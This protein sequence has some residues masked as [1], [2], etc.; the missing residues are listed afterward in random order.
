MRSIIFALLMVVFSNQITHAET[1][2][3]VKNG[4][5]SVAT[6]YGHTGYYYET[7]AVGIFVI[8]NGGTYHIEKNA[9]NGDVVDANGKRI[10][11]FYKF[12]YNPSTHHYEYHNGDVFISIPRKISTVL[13]DSKGI[14]YF[15]TDGTEATDKDDLRYYSNQ[16]ATQKHETYERVGYEV[17]DEGVDA[18]DKENKQR[19]A[20]I[21][22]QKKPQRVRIMGPVQTFPLW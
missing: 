21:K 7:D 17:I 6:S 3:M 22:E 13:D 20:E 10:D 5:G 12:A 19:L 8:D 15:Y 11:T 1:R 9:L 14:H 2:I 4:M 16:M 18:I